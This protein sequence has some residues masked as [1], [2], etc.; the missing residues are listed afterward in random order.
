MKDAKVILAIRE[1]ERRIG[2]VK[3]LFH[4]PETIEKDLRSKI[5]ELNIKGIGFEHNIFEVFV[6]F[7]VKVDETLI[8][9]LLSLVVLFD[10]PSKLK[11]G[12]MNAIVKVI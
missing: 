9:F 1:R 5:I 8:P 4:E 7:D 6:V 3:E 2:H 11:V 10:V 12:K